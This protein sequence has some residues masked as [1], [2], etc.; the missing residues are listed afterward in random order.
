MQVIITDAWL[1]RSRAIHLS[2]V[3]LICALA[4]IFMALLF[5]TVMAY[6]WVLMHGVREGWPVVGS[7]ARLAVQ[8]EQAQR[9]RF[10]RANIDAMARKLGDMQARV[11]QL[12]SLGERVR[13]LAGLP[14]SEV[15]SLPGRGGMLV[16]GRPLGLDELNAALDDLVAITGRRTDLM[17]VAESRLFDQHIRKHLIP[18]QVPVRDTAVGSAFGWRIDPFTGQSALHTGLD[19]SAG[20]GT[21]IVA[22]AGGVVIAQ[23]Y[24]PA[25]GNMVEIDHGSQLVTR[26]AHASKTL[27]KAGDIVRR[28]QK[29]AEVG[30]TGRSTGPHLHFEVWVQG[31]PQ[32]PQKFLFAGEPAPMPHALTGRAVMGHLAHR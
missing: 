5:M 11:L 3:Q 2:G 7:M 32:D 14:A 27:V 24:H 29:I 17:T 8:D 13:G 12:E 4:G 26:Y 22:A 16:A 9:E 23:E 6:H 19:F 15:Q 30:S 20:T 1:A 31:V 10:M 28:G 18:T 21:P 25:Y